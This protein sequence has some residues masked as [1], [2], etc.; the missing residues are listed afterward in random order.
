[1]SVAPNPYCDETESR[2]IHSHEIPGQGTKIPHATAFPASL[3]KKTK[4]TK[5]VMWVYHYVYL[6]DGETG[7]QRDEMTCPRSHHF[8]QFKSSRLPLNA[9]GKSNPAPCW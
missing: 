8:L 2:S 5:L 3:Q 9:L 4:T 7:A 1:M 6:T